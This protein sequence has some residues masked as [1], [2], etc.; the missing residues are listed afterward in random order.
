MVPLSHIPLSYSNVEFSA[1][2]SVK[3]ILK[4]ESNFLDVR[5]VTEMRQKLLLCCISDDIANSICEVENN[6]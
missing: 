2:L 4:N 6:I 3:L 1:L 5:F